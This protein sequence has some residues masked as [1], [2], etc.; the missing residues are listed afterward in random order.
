MDLNVQ[1]QPDIPNI[2]AEVDLNATMSV[3]YIDYKDL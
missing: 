3:S 1:T 2:M